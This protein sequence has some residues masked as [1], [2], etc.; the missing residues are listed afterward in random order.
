MEKGVTDRRT[1]RRGPK[2]TGGDRSAS[3]PPPR[4]ARLEAGAP[5]ACRRLRRVSPTCVCPFRVTRTTNLLERLFVE[6]RRWLSFP[7]PS[8][9]SR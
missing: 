3:G 4:F 6:E 1:Y 7:T 2:K 5:L 8:A 9:R